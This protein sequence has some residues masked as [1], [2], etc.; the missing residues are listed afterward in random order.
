MSLNKLL[1]AEMGQR[2]PFVLLLWRTLNVT[3]GD[4]LR[5]LSK[6]GHIFTYVCMYICTS[7]CMYI[8]MY[9]HGRDRYIEII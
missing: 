1:P 9:V 5:A 3:V 8:C 2:N 7:V 4:P 6:I